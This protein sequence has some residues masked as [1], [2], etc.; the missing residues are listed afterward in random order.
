MT[1]H[2]LW[3]LLCSV[4]LVPHN[5]FTPAASCKLKTAVVLFL[6]QVFN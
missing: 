4:V 5:L 1:I 6:S 3:A 2:Y